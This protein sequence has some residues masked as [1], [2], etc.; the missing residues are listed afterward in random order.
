MDLEAWM[1][2]WGGSSLDLETWV[3]TGSEAWVD[4][5]T[6]VDHEG[7]FQG[8]GVILKFV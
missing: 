7:V 6:W 4:L 8:L 3:G 5:D 2:Q 1:G